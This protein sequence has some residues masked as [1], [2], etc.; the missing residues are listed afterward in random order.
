VLQLVAEQELQLLPPELLTNFSLDLKE[1]TDI[2][3]S[4]SLP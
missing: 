3:F 2:S 4:T 1:V